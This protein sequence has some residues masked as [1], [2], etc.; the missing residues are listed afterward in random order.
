M[1][2]QPTAITVKKDK[3]VKI[4][5]DAKEL[6]KAIV[7][8][9]YQITNM[10]PLID[11]WRNSWKSLKGSPGLHRLTCNKRL[12]KFRWILRLLNS[13]TSKLMVAKPP[14]HIDLARDSLDS[15]Q[16]QRNFKR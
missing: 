5:L 2:I 14:E 9:K 7:K 6:N 3:S 15:P 4:A 12:A 16:F 13:V 10:D 1:F 11:Y 8:G